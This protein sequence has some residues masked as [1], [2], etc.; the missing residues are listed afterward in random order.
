MKSAAAKTHDSEINYAQ[1]IEKAIKDYVAHSP[2]NRF[3][4][5]PDA[6]IWDE[7]LVGFADGGDPLYQ[8]YKKIIGDFHVSPREVLERY[9]D[10][11]GWCEKK[12]LSRVSV[13]SFVLPISKATRQSN[14][15]EDA[16][17]S[18]WWNRTRVQGHEFILRL[19]RHIAVLIEDMGYM[20]VVPEL[21]SWWHTVDTPQGLSSN[22][23]QRHSAYAAGLGTFSLSDGFITPVGIAIRVGSIVSTLPVQASPRTYSGIYGN[24]LFYNGGTCQRCIERCP[25]GAISEKGHDKHKC[26]A[27][28]HSMPERLKQLGRDQDYGSKI[29]GCGL[30]QTKVPCE[31]GIPAK[32]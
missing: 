17:H 22:W 10:S 11:T 23:S 21:C 7:P 30:C 13:I 19:S 15:K 18:L 26:W 8:E 25:A 2:N 3:N 29:M 6:P 24:C 27:Y 5:F 31:N 32:K 9:I 4:G 14:R 12:D 1:I 16:V 28:L 20:A